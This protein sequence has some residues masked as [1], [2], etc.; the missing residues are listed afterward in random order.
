MTHLNCS[1]YPPRHN[2]IANFVE[3]NFISIR[4]LQKLKNYTNIE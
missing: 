4:Q 1:G 3:L 2:S